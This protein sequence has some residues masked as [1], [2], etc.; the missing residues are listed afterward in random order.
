MW[1]GSSKVLRN[2]SLA[3]ILLISLAPAQ[4]QQRPEVYKILGITVEGQ[5]SSDQSAII[6]NTGLKVGDEITIPGEQT[7][8]AIQRLNNLRLFDDI[9]IL[10]ENKVQDGLFLLIRVKENPRLEKVEI[11]GNDELS[12]DDILKKIA[13]I[14]GTIVTAQD[15]S[16]VV[17]ILKHEYDVASY[18]NAKIVPTLVP[19]NDS[20]KRVIL[21]LDIDEG[22][23]VKVETIRF[24]GNKKFDDGDLKSEMKETSERRWWKIFST[25]KFDRK[26][27]TE[28][29]DLILKFYRKNGYRDAELVKDSLSYD[30]TKRYLALD[31]YVYEG[32]QYF[33]R[34]ITWEGNTVYPSD[35][36]SQRLGFK[37]GDLYDQERF[38]KNLR[39]N[40]DETDV[41]SLYSDN[42]YLFVQIE[43]EEKRVANDS[44]DITL[45]IR[46][47]NQF[48]I[49]KVLITG[50]TKT[51]EKVIRRELLTKPG[52]FFSRQLIVRSVRQLAQ[53]NYFNPERIK[54][55]VRPQDDQKTVDLEY[56]VEEKSSDTFNMSVGYSGAFGFNGGLGLS[57]NNFSL[58]EPFRGGAGQMLTFDWQFGVS[59]SYRTFSIGFTEPWML[60]TPTL[61]GVNIFDTKQYYLA[62]VQYT[63]ASVRVG[64]RFKWPDYLFR[65][66]WTIRYQRN[67][68]HP[69]GAPSAYDVLIEGTSTQFGISQVISRNSTDSPIFPTT[70]SSFSLTTDISGGPIFPGTARYHKHVF[71]ADWY[72]PLTTSGRVTLL[73]SNT[74]G[75]IFG[76]DKEFYVPFQDRF[77][78]GGVGLGQFYVTTLRGYEPQ[79][80]GPLGGRVGGN[81]MLKHTVELRFALALN[82]IP[83]YVLG[84]A[85]G[86]NVWLNHAIQ[87][88]SDLKRSAGFGVRLLVNPIGLLGFDYGYGFDAPVPG[89]EKSGWKFHF[90]FGRS[91]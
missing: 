67:E 85:E 12:E 4:T 69:I 22:P 5:S 54:P 87:D 76:F 48:R 56:S 70:G 32:P 23:K 81:A 63:G 73:S 26:K 55:D 61:F 84:F 58:S 72:L 47:R 16:Q 51:Y 36:L 71:N 9:Q 14:K 40:Q 79:S 41:T 8:T 74:V 15:L 6:A 80:I 68:Y 42:G 38:D 1:K 29:K 86:G 89:G 43:P 62:N 28:D 17:R 44:L 30:A 7:R 83:I 53:L 88:P 31:I 33:I 19:A 78:M 39:P 34:S 11:K 24:H 20:T 21:K 75:L 49:G 50:N 52:D 35:V 10:I 13:L 46:E 2:C 66:D 45:K 64:R 90:Q 3:F 25:H 77:F 37:S 59:N 57:F 27:Y 82:P 65:G 18:L 60:N 91:F